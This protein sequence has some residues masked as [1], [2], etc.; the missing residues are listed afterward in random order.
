MEKEVFKTEKLTSEQIQR[1]YDAAL[2]SV[3]LLNAG[4]PEEMLEKE[5]EKCV[6]RNVEH[7]KIMIKK[8]FLE[9]KDLKPL[10]DAIEEFEVK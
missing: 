7:L 6:K 9:E 3:N 8:D 4:K 5:W 2:D 1:H 10:L